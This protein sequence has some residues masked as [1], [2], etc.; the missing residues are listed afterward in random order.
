MMPSERDDATNIDLH[1]RIAALEQLLEVYEQVATDQNRQL[2]ETLE[3]LRDQ[4]RVFESV[5]HGINDG[6]VVGDAQG[7]VIMVNPAAARLC[8]ED[9]RIG[10]NVLQLEWSNVRRSDLS[11]YPPQGFP[12]DLAIAG[13]AVESEEAVICDSGG[14]PER[15]LSVMAHPLVDADDRP[16]G[17]VLVLHDMTPHKRAEAERQAHQNQIISAQAA[18]LRELSTPLIPV[19][20]NVLVMPLIGSVD[21]TRAHHVMITLL[22]GVAAQQATRVILDITGVGVIDTQVAGTLT[23][24]AQALRL[25]G[26]TVILTGIRPEVAQTLVGLGVDLS[27]ITTLGT[28]QAGIRVALQAP[29]R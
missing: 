5:L 29:H 24:A 20:D 23:R 13:H 19:A 7:Q 15:W 12:L 26:A 10:A 17:G 27:A 11:R 6:V 9:L 16:Q 25:L 4:S 1:A 14:Q 8:G 2:A 22:E 18:T 3:T 28:L 21:S